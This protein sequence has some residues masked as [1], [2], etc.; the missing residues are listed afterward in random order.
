MSDAE[1]RAA[2]A[3]VARYGKIDEYGEG[4]LEL[5]GGEVEV[6]GFDYDGAMLSLI[7]DLRG[8]CDFVFELATAGRLVVQFDAPL[9]EACALV[10]TQEV[11]TLTE[12][13][14]AAAHEE[15]GP[16]CLVTDSEALWR[17]LSRPEV[18]P[19]GMA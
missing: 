2:S 8:P 12:A 5:F 13:L 19:R 1:Y 10:T 15:L 6:W 16:I 9:G 7:G 11:L 4:R 14:D 3:V 18:P 17:V